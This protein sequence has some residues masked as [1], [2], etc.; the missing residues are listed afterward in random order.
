MP[1]LI[2]VIINIEIV[3]KYNILNTIYVIKTRNSLANNWKSVIV[4]S[5]PIMQVNYKR[6][7][8]PLMN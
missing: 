5:L 7:L 8:D 4:I 6:N 1:T 3:F 2:N